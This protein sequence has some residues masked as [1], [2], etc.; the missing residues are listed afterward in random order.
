MKTK[1]LVIAALLAIMTGVF[2]TQ[3][4]AATDA[5]IDDTIQDGL[6]WLATQQ[7][8]TYGYFGSGY[9]M[10][11][12]AAA[13][14]AFE[15]EGHFPGGTNTYSTNVEKGLDWLFTRCYKVGIGAQTH[16][17]PDSNGNGQGIYFSYNSPMYETGMVMQAIVA[18]NTPDRVVGGNTFSQ[19]A[20]GRYH[21]VALKTDGS[22]LSW[23]YN[24]HG[25][26]SSTPAGN[27]FVA[28][29]A[30]EYHS[31]ALRDDGSIVS[32]G[33][34]GSGAVSSTPAGNDFEAIAGGYRYSL[35]LKTD[36]SIVGWG[37]DGHGEVSGIP[38]G[39]DFVAIAA[40]IFHNLALK[41]DG[42]IVSWGYDAY[43]QVGGTPTDSG[44]EAIAA[45]GYH[46]L[47]LKD[48]SIDA[49]GY[50]LHG[51][52][53]NTPTGNDFVAMSGGAHHSLVLKTDGSVV[54]WGYDGYGQVSGTYSSNDFVG[55]SAG[56]WHNLALETDGSLTGWGWNNYGQAV[57]PAG[58]CSGMTYQEVMEDVVDYVAWGQIDGGSG[59]GGWIYSPQNNRSS[60]GDN[61]V[62]QWPVLGLV[63]AEQWGIN[64]PAFVKSE[65]NL[66][67]DYIQ[68]DSSGGSGYSTPTQI[69][70]VSKT[71][72]LLVEMY[73]VGD[74]KDTPRA[75]K[76]INYINSR[77]N[78]GISGTW[79]GNIG[80]PYAMFAVFKGLE[81]MQVHTLPTPGDWHYDYSDYLVT[82][83]APA[84]PATTGYWSGYSYWSW[85]MATGWYIV[86][87]QATVFPVEVDIA[88]PTSAC[89]DTGYDVDVHYA[90]ER[91]EADG[92][93]TIYKDDILYDTITLTDFQGSATQSYSL[94]T[95][96]VGTHEWKA[97]LDV[98]GGG[99][100]TSA[101]DT[102]SGEVYDTP[103]VAGILDQTTPFTPFD[104]DDY[105]TCDATSADWSASGAPAGWTVTIDGDNV[106]TVTAPAGAT[107]PAEITFEAIVHWPGI[108]CYGEDSAIYSPNRPPVADPGRD[109]SLG[110]MYY[111]L[112]GET[113]ELDGSDSY[114]PDGDE[115]ISYDWDLDDDSVFETP[116]AIIT[117]DAAG[118]DRPPTTRVYVW[119]QVCDEH[120]ACSEERAR[121]EILDQAPTAAF[122]SAPE[123]Q[124]EGS[125]IDFTDESTSPVDDIV[126]W[127][128]DFAGLGT[129]GDQN[130]SFTFADNG[131]YNVCLTVIDDDGSK[132]TVCNNVTV[133]NVVPTVDAGADGAI[134]EGETFIGSGS[135]Q[136]PGADTWT[137]T[138]DY[139]GGDG[140]EPL[141]L[142]GMAY[143]LSNT[144]GD[145]GTYTAEVCVTDDDGG[146]GCD[147][148]TV[149]VANLD[150]ALALDTTGSIGFAGGDAF[151]GRL[152]V[153]QT[154]DA[155]A[156]DPGS[157]DLTFD[158]T[159]G[160]DATTASNTYYN[161]GIGPD[162]LPSSGG[163]FPFSAADSASVTLAAAGIY[164]VAV[165]VTD[166]DG[167]SDTASLAKIC[168]GDAECTRSQG[169]WKQQFKPRMPGKGGKNLLDE[170]LLGV[171]LAIIR[172][173]SGI[174]DEDVALAGIVDANL[175]FNP[176][177]STGNGN[178]GSGNGSGSGSGSKDATTKGSNTRK[179]QKGDSG[180][181]DD[182]TASTGG[183]KSRQN[184]LKQTL[185]AWLNFSNGAIDWD[186]MIDTD[187][188]GTPD[189]MF[190]DLIGEVE[191]ILANPD[192]TKADLEHAKDLAEAV[193]QH[194]KDNPACQTGTG[195]N[196]NTGSNTGSKGDSGSNKGSGTESNS[197]SKP[198]KKGKK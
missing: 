8:S 184:A 80:H 31:L 102:D 166:D 61:S 160:P 56:Y 34:D 180:S 175:V 125:A 78:V 186:E 49:W 60:H 100:S 103:Q 179:K 55:I 89:D 118:L 74:D 116:G 107:E 154:H 126:A 64:A 169:Y 70:N 18:S 63:A 190:G 87:L 27:D 50:D 76:A 104:L 146:V 106:V 88:V 131:V 32:W 17:N 165:Q 110:E 121:I 178:G 75:Q 132:D 170:E 147:T 16:G 150:P 33:Y 77:W 79:Y 83:Q 99:I 185:A 159:F 44:Y 66:W 164:T 181:A 136:D 46:S 52:V 134:D 48:G 177:K 163:T 142:S 65:L 28:V 11:H 5:E 9:I 145:N 73:Y 137:A 138:V 139:G 10:G 151:I 81:L 68:N 40:G 144:Y 188:D 1:L 167:G 115:I 25:Q 123:P 35:A 161:D 198:N 23:A 143:D 84:E 45:G 173:T 176:P 109:Y 92:T 4:Q 135:F 155:D 194:D 42:S 21:N 129:S 168:T 6:A 37:Y 14:L 57:D 41:T 69:V 62:A 90:V 98:T 53:S 187:G 97:V 152:N 15:N 26:V 117:F 193:N 59:R 140:V 95:A 133:N 112:E 113:V 114:D 72:G 82:T 191:A 119:L 43:N 47:A 96:D 182:S 91:F 172:Y 197:G 196:S 192:A 141:A 13:V 30:G 24:G 127:E 105:L 120:N 54:S 93:L 111:V 71:G 67:I 7:N 38:A 85:S 195:S 86:I 101:E 51:E 94:P 149:T 171:Y 12:T 162:P 128:W 183:L 29:A 157:D 39:N 3:A 130:P 174:F 158:W 19:V 124:D 108:D 156:T 153:E 58:A 189:M 122:S 20:S 148:L 36:G 22:L 2:A